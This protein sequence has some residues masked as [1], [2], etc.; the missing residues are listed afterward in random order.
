MKS[1]LKLSLLGITATAAIASG[2]VHLHSRSSAPL[3]TNSAST[4]SLSDPP[5]SNYFYSDCNVAAQAVVTSPLPDSNLST[6]GPRL[7]IAW[8]AGNSGICTFFTPENKVNGT[9]SVELVNSTIGSPLAPVYNASSTSN[10]PNVGIQ[11]VIRFNSS[12]TLSLPILGSIRTIRD[13]VEGASILYPEIQNA[14]Q[15]TSNSDGSASVERQWLDNVT[16]T[17]LS[18]QPWVNGAIGGDSTVTVADRTL[19]FEAGEYLFTAKLNYPQ[20]ASLNPDAVLNNESAH[21]TTEMPD[22]TTALSFLSYS[23][24]LLAGAWRFLTY[25]G[26]DSM[27]SALLL[28]PVLSNGNG[29]AMEAVL[30][31]VLERTNRTDGSVCHEETIGDYA[32]WTNM[33]DNITSSAMICTYGMID[34]DYYLP[35]LMQRYFLNNPVGQKRASVFFNT[36]AGSINAANKNL[37]WGQLALI[38]AE[39]IMRLTAPFAQNQTKD[40]LIHLKQDQV[41]GQWRDSEFGIGGGRIPFDVNTALAPAALRSIASLARGGIYRNKQ[42]GQLADQYAQIWEDQTLQFFEVS[43]PQSQAQTL[44]KS[45]KNASAF[46]GP[47]QTSSIDTDVTFYA[48]ALDGN[49][50][51][52]KVEVMHTDDCFR[53]YLLNTTNNAQLSRFLNATATNIRR[54]FPAGLMT[55]VGML[56]ANPAFGG[57]VVYAQNWTTGAYHGT[58]VWSWQ[59][60]MMAKGLELQMGRC[61]VR[62][63]FSAPSKNAEERV[64]AVPDFCTDD[65]IF[66][67]VKAAYNALWDSIELN[68]EQLSTEMWSWV[69]GDGKFQL[70]QLVD[71]PPPPGLSGQTES[72]I[73]QLWS[74]AFLAVSRNSNYQ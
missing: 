38:N 59:L 10:Y 58:V 22:Q 57:D 30:G 51:L 4:L 72:D 35:V 46:A 55:D 16:T 69:Y 5:Y 34:P 60:A 25:F 27:I 43:V 71:L 65:S 53:H 1:R 31:A 45:Y 67:N 14:I 20:L 26:R 62:A 24:K 40:N 21:L 37:T 12:A 73:L 52:S 11:G 6:I 70:A 32:T 42:W 66:D 41:V 23:E 64:V 13:F 39:R 19:A 3:C 36:K 7:I 33:Q 47:D 54:T 17:S 49:N 9:L 74:L 56:I 61:E 48:L 44:V 8:P 68:D 15:Y 50:N 63:N 29:T 2:D 18:F 28:E